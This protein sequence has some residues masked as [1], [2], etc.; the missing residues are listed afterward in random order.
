MQRNVEE[1]EKEMS[2]AVQAG[3]YDAFNTTFAYYQG[4]SKRSDSFSYFRTVAL[5][6]RLATGRMLE[7]YSLLQSISV[8]DMERSDVLFVLKIEDL[9]NRCDL[10]TLKKT[11]E[12][13]NSEIK[14]LLNLLVANHERDVEDKKGQEMGEPVIAEGTHESSLKNVRDCVYIAKHFSFH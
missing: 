11:V 8:G 7:Y 2:D 1:L 12:S 5:M 14:G 10:D 9:M 4:C 13:N 3:N 6:Y